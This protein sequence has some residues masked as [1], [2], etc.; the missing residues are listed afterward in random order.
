M[1]EFKFEVR[2]SALAFKVQA[3][4]EEDAVRKARSLLENNKQDDGTLP[5]SLEVGWEMASL[6]VPQGAVYAGAIAKVTE[7]TEQPF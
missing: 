5:V 1:K 2:Q 6:A 3:D 7:L 4:T